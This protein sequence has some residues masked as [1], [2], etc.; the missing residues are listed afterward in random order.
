MKNNITI[1]YILTFAKNTWFWLGIWVFY[2]LTFTDYAGIGIIETT[3]I[4][5]MTLFE[6][7]T[8]AVADLLGKK[9]TLL[10]AFALEFFGGLIMAFAPSFYYIV[11]AVFIMCVGGAFY[12]GTLDAL[13]FDSLKTDGKIDRFDKVISNITSISLIT[14]AICSIIGGYLYAANFRLPFILNA[15]G[16]LMG[17]I[18]TFFLIEPKIDTVKFSFTNYL[19]QTQQ[20]LRQLFINSNITR[21]TIILLTIGFVTVI[22]SEM[23]DSFLSFEFGFNDKQMGI[24]WSII[25]VFT[26]IASQYTEKLKNFFGSK[27]SIYLIGGLMGVTYLVSPYVGIVI[28][29][30]SII[31]RSMSQGV[32]NNLASIEINNST[33]S[34]YRATTISTFNMIKN[35]P[36]VLT[37][38]FIGGLADIVSARVISLYLGMGLLVTLMF[39]L[40]ST[41]KTKFLVN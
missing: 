6:I 7:P 35:V 41:K 12:S 25:F 38:Y 26:A 15:V 37:A 40:I 16:Y 2:Y 32:F 13:V 11:L 4:I 33:E 9:K 5:T 18:A 1:A 19:K 24:L 34:K 22:S 28:G 29:G 23:V 36:Y 21:Q 39:F 27:T 30:V 20:G 17:L 10:L 3:L 31:L 8:G 14:P